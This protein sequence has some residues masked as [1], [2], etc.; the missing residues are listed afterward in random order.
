KAAFD[1]ARIG[2]GLSFAAALDDLTAALDE[3]SSAIVSAPPGAG[4]TTLVPPLLA[5]RTSGRVIVT[6]PRRVAARAAA[7]RLAQLDGSPLGDRVG[8]TVRGE[9]KAGP[10]TRVE[11]V[12]AGVLLRRM[13]NGPGLDG[14]RA[15]IVDEVDERALETDLLIGLLGEVRQLRDDLVLVAMSATLDADRLAAVIGTD[16]APAPVA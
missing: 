14:V 5:S 9:R 15:V 10:Q 4:K 3:S 6:Q 13:L 11:F 8:F 12:T 2:D 16:S 1:L 7:R